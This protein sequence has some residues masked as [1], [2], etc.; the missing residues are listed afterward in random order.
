MQRTIR[1]SHTAARQIHALGSTAREL[2]EAKLAQLAINPSAFAN[3]IKR[4][5]GTEALRL[6]VGDYRI[7][8]TDDCLVLD[9]RKVGSRGAIYRE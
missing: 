8:F 9:I 3:Q 6:R 5:K 7:I 2:V 4:L 1:Y